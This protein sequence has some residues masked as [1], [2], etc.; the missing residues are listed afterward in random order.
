MQKFLQH[1]SHT[2]AL[3]PP[4]KSSSVLSSRSSP[5]S[6]WCKMSSAQKTAW[7]RLRTRGA[8]Q[9]NLARLCYAAI[10]LG[11]CS[12]RC[13]TSFSSSLSCLLS[14]LPTAWME[15]SSMSSHSLPP[16]GWNSTDL[17]GCWGGG[18][19]T[20][21]HSVSLTKTGLLKTFQIRLMASAQ[22]TWT[23]S[24]ILCVREL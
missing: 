5:V 21:S 7:K 4:Q 13:S 6:H 12:R 24:Q 14:L 11:K 8:V 22:S 18:V 15:T 16:H 10:R 20:M 3:S 19:P 1:P 2:R 9:S 17:K 23:F